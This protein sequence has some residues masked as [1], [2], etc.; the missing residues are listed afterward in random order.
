MKKITLILSIIY[1]WVFSACCEIINFDIFATTDIHGNFHHGKSGIIALANFFEQNGRSE[2]SILIDCGDLIQGNAVNRLEKGELIIQGINL[3]QYDFLVPGNH[4]FDFGYE[5]MRQ[6]FSASTAEILMANLQVENLKSVPFKIVEKSGVKFGFIGMTERNLR[7]RFPTQKALKFIDN[8][9]ALKNAVKSLMKSK[10]DIIVLIMHDGLYF[11]GGTIF[12]IIKK[13]PMIDIV[14]GGHT[15]Q[16]EH[17][18]KIRK[19]YFIQSE[20]FG[21]GI[22]QLKIEFD[23]TS[24]KIRR[25]KSEIHLLENY[26]ASDIPQQFKSLNEKYKKLTQ[27][28][29]Q[30]LQ[31]DTKYFREDLSLQENLALSAMK[32]YAPDGD[33][34]LNLLGREVSKEYHINNINQYTLKKILFYEDIYTII[35]INQ[36]DLPLILSEVEQ[37][38]KKFNSKLL[39]VTEDSCRS[40]SKIRLV[41]TWYIAGGMGKSDS[42]IRK[43]CQ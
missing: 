43:L 25:I 14:I 18:K 28:A 40:K 30:P 24:R 42:K 12:E 41:T 16:V 34:Y 29:A 17:G 31:I 9:T 37:S 7:W 4:D 15:H 26:D 11:R 3:L 1:L 20:P 8:D 10:V 19:S 13:F 5:A 6:A 21:K 39:Y 38:S 32:N 23:T 36:K 33:V 2:N 35:E 27:E 22:G